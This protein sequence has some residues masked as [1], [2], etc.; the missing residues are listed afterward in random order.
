MKYIP[1][2][3]LIQLVNLPLLLLG[4]VICLWPNLAHALWLWWNDDDPPW[5]KPWAQQYYWLAL[6]NPVSNLRHVPGIS[7]AGRPL[8][9]WSNG[10]WYAK[11]GWTS[12]TY[13]VLS[14]GSGKGY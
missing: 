5:N 7:G 6:R 2:F 9:Y 12:N 14:L 1:L 3:V 8:W 11:A 4:L 13:P 10:S